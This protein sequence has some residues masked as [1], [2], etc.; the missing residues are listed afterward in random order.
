[1]AKVINLRQ[2]RKSAARDAKRKASAAKTDSARLAAQDKAGVAAALAEAALLQ[3]VRDPG[4]DGAVKG[5][6]GPEVRQGGDKIGPADEPDGKRRD[7]G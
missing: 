6:H 1:M 3:P 4:S 5:P 2:A 7:D